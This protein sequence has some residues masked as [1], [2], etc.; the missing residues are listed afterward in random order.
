MSTLISLMGDFVVVVAV[1]RQPNPTGRHEDLKGW[2]LDCFSSMSS[3]ELEL[4]CTWHEM[5]LGM[6]S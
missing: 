5:K 2:L 6:Q 1:V 3:K 4:M